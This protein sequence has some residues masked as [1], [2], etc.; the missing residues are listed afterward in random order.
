MSVVNSEGAVRCDLRGLGR[1]AS[2]TPGLTGNAAKRKSELL[3]LEVL[4]AL[5]PGIPCDYQLRYEKQHQSNPHG[6]DPERFAVHGCPIRN[7]V[8]IQPSS[9]ASDYGRA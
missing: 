8:P 6:S 2:E 4:R 1:R 7:D 9:C 3:A 5:R